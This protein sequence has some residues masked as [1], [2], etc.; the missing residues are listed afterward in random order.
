MPDALCVAPVSSR[1]TVSQVSALASAT[2]TSAVADEWLLPGEC[3]VTPGAVPEPHAVAQLDA[4]RAS[5]L[6]GSA[7]HAVAPLV[8]GEL[9]NV[10]RLPGAGGALFALGAQTGQRVPIRCCGAHAAA[11]PSP[12]MK[13]WR[14]LSR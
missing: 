4:A 3:L 5:G 11:S 9:T 2:R 1:A 14:S 7:V 10:L 13:T 8:P 6:G 12:A